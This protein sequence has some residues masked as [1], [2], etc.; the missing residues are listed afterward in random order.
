MFAVPPAPEA[1]VTILKY[2][3]GGIIK[4]F[5]KD[6]VLSVAEPPALTA[7]ELTLYIFVDVVSKKKDTSPLLSL[8]PDKEVS[9]ITNLV[10]VELL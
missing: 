10:T 8:L 7:F 3:L 9:I 2:Q 6:I 1:V 5:V 4:V